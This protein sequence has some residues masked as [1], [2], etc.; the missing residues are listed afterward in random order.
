[1]NQLPDPVSFGSFFALRI[2]GMGASWNSGVA[3]GLGVGVGV[4]CRPFW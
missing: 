3:F 2:G 4:P 1:M